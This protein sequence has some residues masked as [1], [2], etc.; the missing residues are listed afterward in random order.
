[1]KT[2][3]LQP[4]VRPVRPYEIETVLL[5]GLFVAPLGLHLLASLAL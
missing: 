2:L 1:M 5:L 4:A 3:P